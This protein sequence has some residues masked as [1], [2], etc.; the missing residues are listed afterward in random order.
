MPHYPPDSHQKMAALLDIITSD[1][2]PVRH[3]FFTRRGGVSAGI[4][5]GLNCGPGSSDQSDVVAMNRA[6]VARS[7]GVEEGALLTLHQVHSAD[8]VTVTAPFTDR[9]RAD[10]MVTVVPNLALGVLTADCQP[11]LFADADAGVIGAAHA[12]WRGTLS[13]VLEATVAAMEAL[14]ARRGNIAAVI[15]PT[16]SQSAYEVG[17]E[18]LASFTSTDPTLA[19][20][21]QPGQGDRMLFDLPG[22]GLHRLRAAGVG[23]AEWTGDCTY[24][25]PERFYSYRRTTHA[26]EADYG[27]LISVIRL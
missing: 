15:G 9:P 6:I 13:G 5:A 27:R 12:G 7:I 2:L 24:A 22:Y 3:G 23:R 18:F 25:D 4:F 19:R 11:V 20:F 26:G 16:I 21:F 14:G 8:V 17:P 1:H 10:A